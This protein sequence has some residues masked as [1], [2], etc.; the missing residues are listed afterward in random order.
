MNLNSYYP[1][2]CVEDVEK[3][4]KYY[5]EH[6]GFMEVFVSDWYVHLQMEGNETVNLAFVAS[7]HPSVPE[8]FRKNAEGVILNFEFADVDTLYSSFQEKGLNIVL[9]LRDEAWGQRHFI[10][11]D[12]AGVMIDV[13]KVIE[14]SEEFKEQYLQV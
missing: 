8:A 7:G 12:P 4:S 6:F 2:L 3:C 9:E 10:L 5:Q 11:T 14:P 13:I 1:V